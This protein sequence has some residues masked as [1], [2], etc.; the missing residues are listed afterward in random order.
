MPPTWGPVW[1]QRQAYLR[2]HH[3]CTLSLGSPPAHVPH[4]FGTF[5]VRR[6]HSTVLRWHHFWCIRPPS[7]LPTLDKLVGQSFILP[8]DWLML[9][10]W[11]DGTP[12]R[13]PSRGPSPMMLSMSPSSRAGSPIMM[14]FSPRS[15]SP[16]FG[17]RSG[18]PVLLRYSPST[19]SDV[20]EEDEEVAGI[21]GGER[22]VTVMWRLSMLAR[23]D[24][25]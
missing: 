14:S 9:R 15:P 25:T 12:I 19:V 7:N 24:W 5:F 17:G 4:R 18:S 10:A 21:V 1:V 2:K 6:D 13:P 23:L 22:C 3:H 8:E 16:G 11:A 20:S